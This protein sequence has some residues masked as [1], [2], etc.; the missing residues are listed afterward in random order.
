M[1]K[2]NK[3]FAILIAVLGVQTLSAQTDVTSTYLTNAGF[4]D[5]SSWITGNVGQATTKAAK[6]WTATSSGDTW[7]YGGAVN[8]GS[9]YTVNS[10]TPP[11][12]NPDGNAEGGALGISAGWGCTVTYKQ[13]VTLPAGVYTLKY[14]AY[15]ANTG[16]TQANNYIGFTSSSVTAY[17]KTTNFTANTWVEESVTFVLSS[18]TTGNISVGMGAIS[19]GSGA[20]AKLFVDGVTL[21]YKPFTDVTEANPVDLTSMVSNTKAAWTGATETPG[22]DGVTMVAV[23]KGSDWTGDALSQTINGLP[24]GNYR[25]EV[26]CQAHSSWDTDVAAEGATGY[27]YLCANEYKLDV[28]I[29]NAD[30]ATTKQL[31]TFEKISI[32]NGSLKISVVNE[33]KA[34]NW[35]SVYVKSLTFLGPDKSLE[36][37][38]FNNNVTAL[39]ALSRE[40]LPAAFVTK[41]NNLITTYGSS[42]ASAMTLSQ[43]VAA[44]EE[45]KS[46]IDLHN[47]ITTVY[48]SLI[49]LIELCNTYASNSYVQD[50][51]QRTT[52]TTAATTASNNGNKATT[53][54]ELTEVYNTLETARQTFV[55]A[56]YPTS[57]N[58]FDMT[59]KI[60]NPSFETGDLTGWTIVQPSSDTGVRPNS[61][62]SYTTSGVDGDYLFN[63]WWQGVPIKQTLADLPM[64]TYTLKVAVASDGCTVYLTADEEHSAGL[65]TSDKTQFIDTSIEFLCTDGETTIG[66]VGGADGDAAA[67]KGFTENGYWWYKADKF[68]L[69]RAFDAKT[70][71]NSLSSLKATA[72]ELLT[73]LMEPGKKSNLQVAYDNADTTSDNP[74]DLGDWSLALEKAI[75]EAQSSINDYTKIQEYINKTKVFVDASKVATYQTK[76]DNC[77]YTA[78]DVENVRQELNVMRFN[79]ASLVF[80]NEYEVKG[81]TGDL[82]N[83]IRSD[84]HWSGNTQSYYDAN[85]WVPN[86][87]GLKHTLSTTVTLPE[88][89]YV[90]K[91]AGR[92]SA[93]A[94]LRLNI[95]NGETI[96]ESVDYTGKGDTGYGIDTSGAANFSAEGAYANDNAGRG[97]EWEFA[98]FELDAETTVTLHVEV[99]YNNIQ[100]RFGSF[101][102]ITL[103]MDDETY[104]TVYGK[105]LDAPLAEAK[106]LVNTLPMGDTEKT[107]L[108]NAIATGEG[109]LSGPTEL[110]AAVKALEDAVAAAKAWRETYYAEKE[111]LVVQLERFEAEYNDAENGALDYMCKTRWAD[112][113]E[114]A[115]N[116]AVAKDN[117]TSHEGLTTATEELIAALDAATVSVGEYA[118]LKTAIDEA[119]PYLDGNDWGSE[120]FQ[121]PESA[122][123]DFNEIKTT[124][125]NAYD[126]AEVDGEGVTSLTE[127]LNNGINTTL[128]APAEGQRFYIKVATEGHGKLGNAWLMTLGATGANNPTGYGLNTDNAAK[129]YLAQAFIF[130]QVEGNLYNISIEREEGTVYLTYGALNGSTAGWKNQQIQATTEAKDKGQ[131]K[132]VPTGK[133]GILKIFNTIDNNYLDCQDGGAIYTDTGIENEEFAFKLATETKV[134]LNLSK[135]GWATLILPFDAEQLPE[136]VEAYSCSEANKNAENE[137]EQLTLEKATSLK[138]NTPYLMSGNEGK[139]DFSGYGLADKDSYKDGLFIGTYVDYVTTPNSDTYVLQNHDG[140]VA[141]YLVGSGENAQPTVKPYRC[142]MV[143]E[144]AQGAPKFSFGRGD[145][146]TSIDNSEFRIQNS[147]FIY[148]LMG[149]KVNTMEKGKMYIVN[150][151]K[152]VIR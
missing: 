120:P 50:E 100:N 69:T 85:S 118:A 79:A 26:Y 22:Y 10:V 145:E 127:A 47:S 94:T 31:H 103:W 67:H 58:S 137:E 152:V 151:K 28:P 77:G 61:N 34:A 115:K 46:F 72:A 43:L 11:A 14:K 57:G 76:H 134:T 123:D 88:G 98:K 30:G 131:F 141:F 40:N 36:E 54:A 150:G 16:A 108:S 39:K 132:I 17:G 136:G 139:Y 146:T 44:N 20:N 87:V 107:A 83:G 89:T 129:G 12:K 29:R 99:D 18:Q 15:N 109:K 121:K 84:Q 133:N 148:D 90:L 126:A 21:T 113:I 75:A 86:F 122:K 143:Y 8:Y 124:A 125:Q 101:S 7:W 110:N 19:G 55:L 92:S 97:W 65:T 64:G 142:Y 53:V 70:L 82:A 25:M 93:D 95:K 119:T 42:N 48:S 144:G 1:K 32:T 116:A 106:T 114:K 68:R 96:I 24:A 80:P 138:A 63:T 4:D 130:T 149:R 6:G 62:G 66:V 3:L 135:V 52:L 49:N 51:A 111:K 105:E 37:A 71:Q 81:W 41:I 23:Y 102:D 56:A 33:K 78:A 9:S 147:E 38:N 59:F 60:T 2:L 117:L 74:F 27:T 73:E 5:N 13:E 45:I 35:I 104:V 140:E 112:A 128:N 91:A